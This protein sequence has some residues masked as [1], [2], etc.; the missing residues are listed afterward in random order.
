[1]VDCATALST[2]PGDGVGVWGDWLALGGEE[3]GEEQDM[4]E[5][6]RTLAA[7]WAR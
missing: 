4:E 3:A 1:M 2:A 5:E 7:S 6:L